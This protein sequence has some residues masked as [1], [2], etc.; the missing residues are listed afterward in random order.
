MA[1]AMG[2]SVTL[3]AERERERRREEEDVVSVV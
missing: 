1:V 2:R 3:R